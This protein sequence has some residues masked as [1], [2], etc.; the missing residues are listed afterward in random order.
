MWEKMIGRRVLKILLVVCTTFILFSGTMLLSVLAVNQNGDI[1]ELN[2]NERTLGDVDVVN[3]LIYVLSNRTDSNGWYTTPLDVQPIVDML[4]DEGLTVDV[5]DEITLPEINLQCMLNYSQIWILEGDNDYEVEVTQSEADDLY[6]FY[7]N[8]GGV[9]ISWA[10]GSGWSWSEDAL[11]FANRFFVYCNKYEFI[12]GDGKPVYSSHYLF[13]DVNYIWFGSKYGC[14][15]STN[16]NF[17]SIWSGVTSCTGIGIID[18]IDVGR[19]RCVFDSGW[20][21]G[22]AYCTMYDDLVFARNVAHWLVDIIPPTVEISKPEKA[23]Y[24]L[25]FHIRDFLF[26]FRKP[27]ILGRIDIVINATDD[28]SG[29]DYVEFYI[30][31]EYKATDESKP[32][33]WQWRWDS[34]SLRHRHTMKVVAY[35]LAGNSNYDEIKVWRFF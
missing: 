20:M 4:H 13:E 32:Y 21:I 28:Q 30:D 19:G 2:E 6:T 3:I 31:D 14:I 27:V 9:W 24:I 23:L 18:S 10:V 22:G 33:T 12:Y 5:K 7:E 11:V 26:Q 16:P 1:F 25:N 34:F 17:K 15:S 35:D 8:G 29:I